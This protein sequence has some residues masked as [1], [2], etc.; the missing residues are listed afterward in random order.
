MG[1]INMVCCFSSPVHTQLSGQAKFT[2]FIPYYQPLLCLL[3]TFYNVE[4]YKL[5]NMQ[6]VISDLLANFTFL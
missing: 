1:S 6:F 4:K 2:P 3:L 5:T